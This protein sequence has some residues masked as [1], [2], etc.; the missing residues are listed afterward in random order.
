MGRREVL[1]DMGAHPL[2][3]LVKSFWRLNSKQ[4]KSKYEDF[5]HSEIVGLPPSFHP[6]PLFPSSSPILTLF[7]LSY[8]NFISRK[9]KNFWKK[10]VK[11]YRIYSVSSMFIKL[12]RLKSHKML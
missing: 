1:L 10:N 8:I 9:I 5:V 11:I 7:L 12:K 3:G 4:F 2:N 6:P